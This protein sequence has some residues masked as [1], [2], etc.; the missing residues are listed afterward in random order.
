MMQQMWHRLQL[1]IAKGVGT[2]V[3]RTKVQVSVLDD[4]VPPNVD[5]VEPYGFNH[6]PLSGCENYLVFPSGDRSHGIALIVGDKRY[7]IALKQ[8]EVALSDDLGQKVHLKRTGIL[9]DTS[10]DF[11]I[12]AKN[13]K[14]H[15]QETYQFDVNGQGQKWD[16]QGVETW[17]DDDIPKPHHPHSPPEIP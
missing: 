4:E 3:S 17:Q 16:G 6:W 8:G 1:M 11:E 13:I 5:R 12:R 15:A 10:L 2:R 7:Q 14:L 9:I